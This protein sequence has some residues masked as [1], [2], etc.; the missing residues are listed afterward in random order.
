VLWDAPLIRIGVA[1]ISA[2]HHAVALAAHHGLAD[3]QALGVTQSLWMEELSRALRGEPAGPAIP[4]SQSELA[5]REAHYLASRE[6]ERDAMFWRDC[7]AALLSVVLPAFG[8]SNDAR[9]IGFNMSL[10]LCARMAQ[11]SART[12]FSPAALYHAATALCLGEVLGGNQAL[13]DTLITTRTR[14]SS[15]DTGTHVNLL[16]IGFHLDRRQPIAAFLREVQTKVLDYVAHGAF[17]FERIQPLLTA[18]HIS[19]PFSWSINYLERVSN[20]R[21]G[22]IRF[23]SEDVYRNCQTISLELVVIADSSSGT[24]RLLINH[25][26]GDVSAER[27]EHI[28]RRFLA[29]V[30]GIIRS[31]DSVIGDLIDG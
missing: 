12:G 23:A 14:D 11:W 29:L 26:V 20:H 22:E 7:V 15:Q 13:F 17:G 9:S 5:A 19:H 31:Q 16:P 6:M 25:R 21:D 27:A 18:A 24:S 1:R 28:G 8:P 3:A 2:V 30:E 10:R 4:A